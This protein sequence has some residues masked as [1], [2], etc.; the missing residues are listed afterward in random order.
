L[1][2]FERKNEHLSASDM[3]QVCPKMN[4]PGKIERLQ[5][6]LFKKMSIDE[7]E[8]K[9]KICKKPDYGYRLNSTKTKYTDIQCTGGGEYFYLKADCTFTGN[10]TRL[11]K[12]KPTKLKYKHGEV[13]RIAYEG[14]DPEFVF[15]CLAPLENQTADCLKGY[16]VNAPNPIG[17]AYIDSKDIL[18]PDEQKKSFEIRIY[19]GKEMN[20]P[21][22]KSSELIE[23]IQVKKK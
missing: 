18:K 11:L 13:I 22:I 10:P 21:F 5:E 7:R 17:V 2:K 23:I 16:R 9:E 19:G 20:S 6:I 3:F 8:F 15:L 4:E 14:G 1:Y 12:I